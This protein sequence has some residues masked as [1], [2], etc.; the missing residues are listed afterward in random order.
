MNESVEWRDVE[1]NR[2]YNEELRG[3]ERRRENDKSLTI[4]E[5]QGILDSL[6][7]IDGNDQD[8]RGPLGD[9]TISAQ[10]AAYEHFIGE[11]EAQ[12][13]T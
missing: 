13:E 5:L 6:Y 10:I 7:I 4:E 2:I 3:L 11:W 1:Y 8:G 12:K 9:T